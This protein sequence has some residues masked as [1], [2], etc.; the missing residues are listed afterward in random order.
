MYI[1]FIEDRQ[2]HIHYE[3]SQGHQDGQ[4]G[5]GVSERLRL[6]LQLCA[7]ARRNNFSRGLTNEVRRV[8]QSHSRL[9]IKEDRHAGEL[10]QMIHGLRT[11]GRL[12]GNQF[13]KRHQLL[14]V[15]RFDVEQSEVLRVLPRRILHLKDY[16][17]LILGLLNQ[18]DIVLRIGI[19]QQR[20]NSGLRYA[21][22]LRLIAT[23]IDIQ[24]GSVIEK[25][26]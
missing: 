1:T 11:E 3:N 19:A 6:A 15:I 5:D 14:A 10:V 23:D 4:T 18:V 17:I 13:A 24:V 25:I 26:G 9:Q 22:S 12:P 21:I 2:N 8:T 7:D 20:K 16:L